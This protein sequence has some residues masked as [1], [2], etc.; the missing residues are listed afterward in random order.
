MD[1]EHVNIV[2]VIAGVSFWLLFL[3]T[4]GRAGTWLMMRNARIAVI[5]GGAV[6]TALCGLL[7][8]DSV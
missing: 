2:V 3:Y 8:T 5:A 4:F 1:G 7:I 6:W